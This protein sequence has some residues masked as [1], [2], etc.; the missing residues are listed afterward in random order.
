[1]HR[2]TQPPPTV[3]GHP[4][5]T[6]AEGSVTLVEGETQGK[7]AGAVVPW[8]T[9]V[10]CCKG[11]DSLLLSPAP[12]PCHFPTC[13]ALLSDTDTAAH[14]AEDLPCG[15]TMVRDLGTEPGEGP[16][17][18]CRAL[19]GRGIGLRAPEVPN[20]R[21]EVTLVVSQAEV[22]KRGS[23]LARDGGTVRRGPKSL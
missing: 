1:M 9:D 11:T 4:A 19:V 12:R 18:G 2:G 23:G 16:P 22:H 17:H 6:Q 10:G 20:L 7:W 3:C 14:A 5:W 15:G 13:C 8:C 21:V